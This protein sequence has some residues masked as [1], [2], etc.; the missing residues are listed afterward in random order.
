MIYKIAAEFVKLNE[1]SG[2]IQNP[3]SCF[4]VEI[5]NQPKIGSGILLNPRD[6]MTFSGE[7][8]WAR[9]TGNSKNIVELRV[10]PFSADAGGGS[11]S[12]SADEQFATDDELQELVDDVFNGDTSGDV[13]PDIK[14]MIDDVLGPQG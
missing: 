7:T 12:G 3:S 6:K 5:S 2:T 10:V 9:R 1:T 14:E 11:G 8:L 13:D 4:V